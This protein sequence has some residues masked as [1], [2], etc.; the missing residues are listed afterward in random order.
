[1]LGPKNGFKHP[2]SGALVLMAIALVDLQFIL[3]KQRGFMDWSSA[4]AQFCCIM[5]IVPGPFSPSQHTEDTIMASAFKDRVFGVPMLHDAAVS[6]NLASRLAKWW[7]NTSA[8][9]FYSANEP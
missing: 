9:E 6:G 1:M 3:A 2:K 8:T 5:E 7:T 4:Q